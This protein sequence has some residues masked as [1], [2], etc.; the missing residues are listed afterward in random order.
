MVCCLAWQSSPPGPT[1]APHMG[2]E[3]RCLLPPVPLLLPH[4][5]LSPLRRL[6]R[7]GIQVPEPGKEAGLCSPDEGAAEDLPVATHDCGEVPCRWA[8]FPAVLG[9]PWSAP[10]GARTTLPASQIVE[11]LAALRPPADHQALDAGVPHHLL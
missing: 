4:R 10:R 1:P 2:W 7:S 8:R 9:T 5:H 11:V 3:V 6:P